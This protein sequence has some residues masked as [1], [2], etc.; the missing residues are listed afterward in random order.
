MSLDNDIEHRLDDIEEKIDENS[1]ILRSI[2]RKQTFDFWLGIAKISIFIGLFYY[3]YKFV[4]PLLIQ[5]KEAYVSFQGLS[6]SVDSF[7]GN[8]LFD[9]FKNSTTTPQR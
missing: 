1:K 8:P 7:K 9:F 5:F 6:E 4:E 3:S 2:K